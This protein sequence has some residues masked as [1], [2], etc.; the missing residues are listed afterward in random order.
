MWGYE[1][2]KLVAGAHLFLQSGYAKNTYVQLVFEVLEAVTHHLESHTEFPVDHYRRPSRAIQG[3][4][5]VNEMLG[6]PICP[7]DPPQVVMFHLII[8]FLLIQTY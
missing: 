4:H 8:S 5:N 3:F 6:H 7:K 1:A 2:K